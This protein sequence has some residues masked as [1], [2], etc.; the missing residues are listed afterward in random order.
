MK[1]E[2]YQFLHFGAGMIVRLDQ[3]VRVDYNGTPS[4]PGEIRFQF[5]DGTKM[6][7]CGECYD[8]PQIE[9]ML[10]LTAGV[11]NLEKTEDAPKA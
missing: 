4:N 9:E 1:T 7:S 6:T 11:I 5:K 10:R 3:L 2:L 8:I